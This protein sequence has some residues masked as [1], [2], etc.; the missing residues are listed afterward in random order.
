M[1]LISVFKLTVTENKEKSDENLER[2]ER[3][4]FTSK[5]CK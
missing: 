2:R 4:Q 1:G 5:F 3:N